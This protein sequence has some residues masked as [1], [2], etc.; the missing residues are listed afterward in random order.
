MYPVHDPGVA[1]RHR[2]S[3]GTISSDGSVQVQFLRG[4]RL[5]SVEEQFV[6]RLRP[7]DRF[8]FGGRLLE[9]VRLEQMTAYVRL[10]RTGNGV[11]PRWQ[12]GRLPMS[13]ALGAEME[14]VLAAPARAPEI[15]WLAPLL[16]LQARISALPGPDRLLVEVLRRRDGQY[17]FV[18]PFAGRQ[19][20]EGMAAL[21]ALRWTRLHPNTFNF[22]ATDHGFVL[23]P[24][25]PV[26]VDADM[27]RAA[28]QP[29]GLLED[30]HA[31]VNLGELARRQFRDIA[32]V[33]GLLIPALPGRTPRSLRQL[34]ASAGLLYDVLR[35]HDPGHM[36]LG[37]AEREVLSAQLD[38]VSLA[39]ALQRCQTRQLEL[40][41]PPTLGP[42]SFP[43]W[44][45]R[46][47]GQVSNEDWKTR[48]R[49]A[50]EQLE[51]R[52]GR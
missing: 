27:L 7:G 24:A 43:L 21:I 23:A 38:V 20:H 35:E 30:L 22:A 2:L 4:G 19:V 25:V 44:A 14:A 40:Q 16:Q 47:R 52:H 5:G 51:T 36:L 50:A 12:G 9:L 11:V 49:R 32:R 15:R 3:I 17:V 1:L 26:A 10:A 13:E 31:S 39:H 45:E 33:A 29:H 18:Y 37:L 28:L 34:Q 41:Y 42:L 8:Q 48:V 6:S 46:L